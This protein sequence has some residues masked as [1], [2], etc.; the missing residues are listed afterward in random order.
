MISENMKFNIGSLH[1]N[2]TFLNRIFVSGIKYK[3]EGKSNHQLD[4]LNLQIRNLADFHYVV[5]G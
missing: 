2:M 3:T 4:I 1:E 5:E